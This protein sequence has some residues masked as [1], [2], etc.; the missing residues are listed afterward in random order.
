LN[1][2]VLCEMPVHSGNC[3]REALKRV[4]AKLREQLRVRT[5]ELEATKKLD[6]PGVIMITSLISHRTQKPRIDIQVGEIHTQMSADA[7]MDV[8]KNIIECATG[9]YADAF[10]F[11]FVEEELKQNKAVAAGLIEGFRL[12]REELRREFEADQEDTK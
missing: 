2:C 4:I 7:A 10:L 1:L 11:H 9:A 12:Y 3:E 6:A 8:A 5:L